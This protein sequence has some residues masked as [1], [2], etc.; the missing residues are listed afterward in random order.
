MVRVGI[1]DSGGAKWDLQGSAAFDPQ[2]QIT[3]ARPDMLGHG[4][5]VASVISQGCPGASLVHAQVMTDRAVTSALRVAAALS[6]LTNLGGERRVDVVCMSFGLAADRELLRLSINEAFEAGIILIASSPA[7]RLPEVSCY[8]ADYECVIAA[9]GD[10]RCDWGGVSV[11][12]P[13]L[14]GTWSNSPEQGGQGAAGAS[15]AAAR[16]AGL[17]AELMFK[18][19]GPLSYP[20]IVRTLVR[21]ASFHGAEVKR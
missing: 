14:F 8:P 16:L 13:K 1:I 2:G 20:D 11:L 12:S 4:T 9:T 10:A 18:S 6:W 7:R 15:I 21:K 19:S 17:V 3:D 5:A